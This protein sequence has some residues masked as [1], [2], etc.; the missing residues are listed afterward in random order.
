MDSTGEPKIL[1]DCDLVIHFLKGGKIL[2]L[3]TIFPGRFVMLDKVY[4]EL[5][6]RISNVLAIGIFLA[7]A[8][9]PVIPMPTSQVIVKEYFSLRKI[10]DDGESACLAVAK[11]QKEYVA[12]SNISQI[13]DFCQLHG[14]VYYTTMD[15]LQEATIKGIMTDDECNAFIQEVISKKSRLPNMTMEQ[16]RRSKGLI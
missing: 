11:H 10:M 9:V 12:S 8:K 14:I 1:L 4:N 6:K 2:E 15:L 3:P 5:M 16:F 13:A 7:S